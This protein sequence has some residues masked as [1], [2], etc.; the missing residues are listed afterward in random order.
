MI[1]QPIIGENNAYTERFEQ[2]YLA[3]EDIESF[4]LATPDNKLQQS[5]VRELERDSDYWNQRPWDL[6][7]TD[8]TATAYFLGEQTEDGNYYVED[9][10]YKDNRLFTGVRAIMSYAFG[11]LAKPE[12]TPSKGDSV[13]LKAARD[14]QMA[15]YQHS[16][17]EKADRK[18]RAAGLNMVIRKRGFLKLRY[19]ENE[20]YDGDVVTEICNPEDII[21]SRDAKYLSNPTRIYHRLRC[22]VDEL[23]SRFP[24]KKEDILKAFGI[25]QGRFTQMS[26]EVTYFE[27]WFT[28]VDGGK[29]KEAVAWFLQDSELILDKMPNPNWIYTGNDKKDKEVNLVS[30]P[31]KPFVTFNYMNLGESYIDETSLLEQ[32]KPQQELVNR[33]GKQI[34]DNADYVN[35]RWVASKEAFNEEDAQRLINKG[36]KTVALASAKD[37]GN[38]IG[39]A[40][41]NVASNVLPPYMIQTLYDAR[42]EVDNILGT[43]AQFRGAQPQSQDTATR[44]LL[45]KQQAGALQDDLVTAAAEAAEVYYKI[46]LQLMKV[47]YSEDHWFTCRGA[48]GKYI[49]I[50]LNGKNID[51][52]VKIGVQTDSTLPLDKQ[53]I[54]ATA[55]NL[56][57]QN[58]IDYLTLMQ[59][60]GLPDPEM[61]AERY[62]RSQTDPQGYLKSIELSEIDTE[63]EADIQLIIAGKEPDEKDNYSVDYINYF[64]RF[65]TTNRFAKLKPEE[66]QRITEWLMA[67][68]H[69][70]TNTANLQALLLDDAGM[71]ITQPAPAPMPGQPPMG[72]AP[73]PPLGAPVTGVPAGSPDIASMEVGGASPPVPTQ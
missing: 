47:N 22:S 67:V 53:S 70:M 65:I 26:K 34:T 57:A 9:D 58:K 69:V 32:A 51:S 39:N 2:L 61:R 19:D 15:L 23:C 24:D 63:A 73:Q 68:Q 11:Q 25:I 71:L 62:Y 50:M 45:V 55:M 56:S 28:Y 4:E 16:L 13:Y 27:C 64:N 6:K 66:Q 49:F 36:P 33:R 37:V 52:N 43:P 44:D 1:P 60:L 35:G 38:N 7:N 20:G 41:V 46:K 21:I 31:P 30:C 42:G 40:L 59:D 5:L 3:P 8:K 17:D 72:G 14:L 48:D 29:K 10:S 18:F 54:R 12:L